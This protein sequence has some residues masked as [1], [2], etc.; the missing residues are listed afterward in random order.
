MLE[1]RRRPLKI[2]IRDDIDAKIQIASK[3]LTR[4]LGFYCRSK[5]YL[6]RM[7]K[8]A[9]RLDLDDNTSGEVTAEE[10]E[11]AKEKL[12]ARRAPTTKPKRA[13]PVE[14]KPKNAAALRDS[15]ARLREAGRQR[16]RA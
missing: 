5:S 8:G 13:A 7:R 12:A 3:D 14:V 11:H 9:W 2:G 16:V 1:Y 15:I 4:A 6:Q 10:E